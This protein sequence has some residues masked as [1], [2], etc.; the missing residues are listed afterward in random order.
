MKKNIRVFLIGYFIVYIVFVFSI[1]DLNPINWSAL[2]VILQSLIGIAVGS[3]LIS[4][5]EDFKY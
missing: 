2:I 3:A 4:I 1:W 5:K